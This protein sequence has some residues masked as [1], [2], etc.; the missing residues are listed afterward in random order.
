M[1]YPP[2]AE[3]SRLT[4]QGKRVP[5]YREIL[6]DMETPVSAFRKIARG[7]YSFLLESV[8]GGERL[9][10]YS[11]LGSEP[12]RVLELDRGQAR[13]TGA[14]GVAVRP[15]TDPLQVVR[16]EL[17]EYPCEAAPGL[18]RFHGGAV[19][20]LG[21]E[22]ARYFERLPA[23]AADPLGLP[24]AVLMFADTLL[25]F[26][27]LEHKIKV[28]SHVWP[29]GDAAAAYAGAVA[30]IDDLINRLASRRPRERYNGHHQPRNATVESNLTREDFLEKVRAAKRYIQA[31]DII[32]VVPSQRLSRRLQV[33]PF[34]V[35]RAL[36]TINPSPYMY[37]LQLGDAHIVGASPEMLVRVEAGVVT[38]HPIAGTRWRGKTPDE[39]EALAEEL[40]GD[41]KE[42]AEHVMLVDL[43]RNDVGRVS[44]PGSVSTPRLMEVERYSHVMHLVSEVSGR[45]RPGLTAYD[46]LRACFPAGTVSGAPKIRAM[47]IIAG[48]EPQRRG[49]YAGAVGYFDYSGNLDT[50]IT[51]RTIVVRDGVAYAQAGGGVVADSE[52]EREYEETLNK[53]AALVK[54]MEIAETF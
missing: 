33:E 40:R 41:E 7:N 31:G 2:L 53:A 20:Y 24:E 12:Y 25:V 26:D 39:D 30:R 49:P 44:V 17:E 11:F 28:V 27:H 3:V 13:I 5:I 19:G 42:R 32:Q 43:S 21:Y 54:A 10:R 15:F 16:Q 34:N 35:Y 22:L 4:A 8:V 46:A 51:I 50:A 37:Y 52:P 18:P 6:A 14:E 1:Y 48:L 47:E 38:S 29:N 9:G 36:R 45:L 23:P